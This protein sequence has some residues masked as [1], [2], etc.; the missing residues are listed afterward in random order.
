[1]NHLTNKGL[2]RAIAIEESNS[3]DRYESVA[4]KNT[5]ENNMFQEE[6]ISVDRCKNKLV[7]L[8]T[9]PVETLFGELE[10]IVS[11]LKALDVD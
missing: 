2:G 3:N 8:T 6:I 10:Y 7:N 4:N 1:M 5:P 11:R 9:T